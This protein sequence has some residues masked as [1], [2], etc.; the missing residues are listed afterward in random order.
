VQIAIFRQRFQLRLRPDLLRGLGFSNHEESLAVREPRVEMPVPLN[1][2]EL[3]ISIFLVSFRFISL[4]LR[5]WILHFLS[6][7]VFTLS[8]ET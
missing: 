5:L 3:L 7:V 2:L 6:F 1:R 4:P 8:A